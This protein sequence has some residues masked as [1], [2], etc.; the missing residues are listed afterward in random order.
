MQFFKWAVKLRGE[1]VYVAFVGSTPQWGLMALD[2]EIRLPDGI[3]FDTEVRAKEFRQ[4]YLDEFDCDGEL[5]V[6]QVK[7][8]LP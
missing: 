8:V 3:M 7:V 6:V 2:R 1:P 5:D 4:K